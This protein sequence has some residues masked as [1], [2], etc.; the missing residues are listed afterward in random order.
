MRTRG[1]PFCEPKKKYLTC[2]I[3]MICFFLFP[4]L[5]SKFLKARNV[6]I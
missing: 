6:C 2:Y 1:S 5:D 4:P 3:K